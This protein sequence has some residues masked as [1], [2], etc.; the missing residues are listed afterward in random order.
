[1]VKGIYTSASG[2]MAEQSRLDIIANNLANVDKT[3]FKRDTMTFKAFPEMRI[4]RTD[5]DGL[6]ITPLGST[7]VRP[8]IGR[9][10]TGVEVN[11]LFTEFEQG[12]LKETGNMLD[13]A[14]TDKGFIAVETEQGER[15]TR[16][17]SFLIDKD[18]YLVTKQGYK[19]L[20]E[21]GY[22]KIKSNNFMIDEKGG[23]TV[24]NEYQNDDRVIQMN[25]NTW[26]Q[27]EIIDTLKIV[28]FE[29]ERFLKK[30]G[31][32]LWVDTLVSGKAEIARLEDN[33]RPKVVSGYLEMSNVNPIN[34]MVRMIEVQRSYEL[35]SKSIMTHD[36]L[37]GKAVNEIGRV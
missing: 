37:V 12:S 16:N 1:M 27:S 25:D 3:G 18:N 14:L 36:A 32:S 9:M 28:R 29:N 21:N 24:N 17:G 13:V 35:N 19:V 33:N 15:Y 26:E 10:G 2:M 31:E 11:E 5:D 20:G 4:S 22:I 8:Y 7:D 34:E 23:I 30:E 6:V